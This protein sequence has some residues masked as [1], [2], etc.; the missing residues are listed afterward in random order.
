MTSKKLQSSSNSFDCILS[1]HLSEAFDFINGVGKDGN[2]HDRDNWSLQREK[3]KHFYRNKMR[4]H[5]V[6]ETENNLKS[7]KKR[8]AGDASD[9]SS[10]HFYAQEDQVERQRKMKPHRTFFK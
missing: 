2:K 3:L 9:G 6:W 10:F 1:K 5:Q 8:P 7:H 4:R